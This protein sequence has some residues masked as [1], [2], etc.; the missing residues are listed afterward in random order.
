MKLNT[1][2]IVSHYVITIP[3]FNISLSSNKILQKLYF[4]KKEIY[5]LDDNF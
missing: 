4:R 2:K 1:K 3:N 5:L